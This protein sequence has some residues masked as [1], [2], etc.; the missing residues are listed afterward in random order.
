MQWRV[1]NGL[2]LLWNNF[3]LSPMEAESCFCLLGSQLV[4]SALDPQHLACQFFSMYTQ[5]WDCRVMWYLY[6][7]FFKKYSYVLYNGCTNLHS[8][9]DCRS[10]PFS[11]HRLQHLL[12]LDFLIMVILTGMRWYFTVVLIC[13]SLTNSGVEHLFMC[14]L[15]IC[16]SSL[17][18]C[19]FRYS[20][21]V[22]I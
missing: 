19:L 22:F 6:F 2:C 18:K 5:E 11:P 3:W 15:A 12:F 13:I 21:D 1:L 10:V 14:L 20:A 7:Y 16:M 8:H 9:Q 4:C 17:E